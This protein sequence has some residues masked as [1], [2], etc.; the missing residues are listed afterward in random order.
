MSSRVG[1]GAGGDRENLCVV[2]E[3]HPNTHTD[4]N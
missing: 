3:R 2:E 4:P 1:E